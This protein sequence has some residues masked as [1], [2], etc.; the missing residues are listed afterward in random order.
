MPSPKH[1]KKK[2]G[3]ATKDGKLD[4]NLKVNDTEFPP[5]KKQRK[6]SKG[7]GKTATMASANTNSQNQFTGIQQQQSLP[8]WQNMQPVHYSQNY[9]SVGQ[10]MQSSQPVV[11]PSQCHT[12]GYNTNFTNPSD[13]CAK[14][15]EILNRLSKLDLIEQKIDQLYSKVTALDK[16]VETVEHR[17]EEFETSVNFISGKVDDFCVKSNDLS[18]QVKK[19]DNDIRGVKTEISTISNSHKDLEKT[20]LDLM[21]RSMRDNLLFHGISEQPSENVENVVLTLCEEKLQ[22]A[23]AKNNVKIERAHRIGKSAPGKT[24]PIVVKFSS[25]KD[26]ESIRKNSKLLK[27][28]NIGISEQFPREIQERRKQLIPV[29][30]QAQRD[31]K[32]ATLSVDRLYIDGRLYQQQSHDHR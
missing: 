15:D 8:V 10:V 20:C 4:D 19:C 17:S 12:P 11:S 2:S 18:K 29:M 21:C 30:K 24:R 3:S 28:T 22:I 31:G 26:R 25:H 14:L 27:G 13:M 16:R 1:R 32:K 6:H 7:K 5:K 23:D 9:P